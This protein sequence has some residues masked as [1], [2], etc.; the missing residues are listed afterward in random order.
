MTP[1]RVFFSVGGRK[2][3]PRVDVA[4]LFGQRMAACGLS[5]DWH[6][7]SPEPGPPLT[8]RE[9]LGRPAWVSC[10]SRMPGSLGAA[11]T[12]AHELLADLALPLLILKERY[13]LI[14][15]RDKFLAGVL[16]LATARLK[17]VPFVFW[18][19]YP[20]PEAR[21]LDAREG[22]SAHPWFSRLSGRLSGWLLYRVILRGADHVF[23]QSEQMK[24]DVLRPGLDADKFTSVPMGIPDEDMPAALTP[25]AER[26]PW[27][28]YL[29][30]LARVRRLEVLL[31]AMSIVVRTRPDARLAFIGEGDSPE[32]RAHLEREC[33]RLGLSAFVTFTGQVC[34]TD[35][36]A[37]VRRARV[38]LSP[39][40]PTFVLRST[41]PTKL[42][43][44]MA[45]Q[46]PV[47]ANDHPEQAQVLSDSGAGLCVP[48]SAEAFARAVLHL[49]DHP[50]EA[51]ARGRQGRAWVMEHRR[52]SRIAA[53]ILPVYRSLLEH[54]CSPATPRNS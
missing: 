48:W 52:Y 15:V 42:I 29:G 38:C 47:V 3:P 46:R 39:F 43:E 10:R 30:T 19:S 41:S 31:E 12:K 20:F 33:G 45:L 54:R 5:I 7:L 49:L 1:A 2:A 28:V 16:G 11:I 14:Q 27:V 44:Y 21:L 35:A 6:I 32:D 18:L 13:D 22:R 37:W 53:G 17:G 50:D 51:E 24:Q 23:V 8:R 36:L 34:R 4:D 40:Y 26:T 9:W 25:C